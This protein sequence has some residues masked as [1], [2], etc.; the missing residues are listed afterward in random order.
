MTTTGIHLFDILLTNEFLI[1]RSVIGVK[2]N[3]KD[4]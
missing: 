4:D 2:H 1:V 3:K